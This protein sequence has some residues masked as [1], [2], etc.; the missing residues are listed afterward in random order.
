MERTFA[1]TVRARSV[2]WLPGVNFAVGGTHQIGAPEA[3]VNKP[4]LWWLYGFDTVLLL[5]LG[6]LFADRGPLLMGWFGIPRQLPILWPAAGI[7]RLFG[8][9]LLALGIAAMG[10]WRSREP[11]F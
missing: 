6:L 4:L 10:V 1:F 2:P 7:T 9:A 8:G 5:T 3:V 11:Q